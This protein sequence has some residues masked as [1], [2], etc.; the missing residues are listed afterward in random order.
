MVFMDSKRRAN[1]CSIFTFW[2]SNSLVANVNLN[3]GKLI[4]KM[5]EDMNSDPRRDEKLLAKFQ[6]SLQVSHA[7][8]QKRNPG[9]APDAEY[10]EFTKRAVR[11]TFGCHFFGVGFIT[12]L[13]EMCTLASIYTIRYLAQYLMK[14]ESNRTEA[15]V[16]LVIFCVSTFA[17]ALLRNFYIY[18]GYVMSLEVRKLLIAA[19]YDKVSKL[20]MR[21]LTETNSGKLITLVS[22]DIFT[23][24]RPLAMTPFFVA[25]PFVN[26]VCYLLVWQ[27]AGWEYAVAVFGLWMLTFL[28]QMCTTRL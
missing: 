11:H 3:K 28:L 24:E 18:L 17:G 1:C 4:D 2:Y 22:S 14:E 26:I 27:L 25:A 16:L 6:D 10:Y 12:F 15:A 5:I 21:S 13:A 20:S 8:W 9:R 23:L 19:M 7:A